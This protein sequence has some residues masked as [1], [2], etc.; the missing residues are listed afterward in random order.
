MANVSREYLELSID[1]LVEIVQD[2][3]LDIISESNLFLA[4]M[5]WVEHD[6]KS[7]KKVKFISIGQIHFISPSFLILLIKIILTLP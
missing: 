5:K 2:D 7:R 3:E 4:M 1:E 6:S